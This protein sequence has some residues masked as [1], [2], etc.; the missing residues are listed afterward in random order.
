VGNEDVDEL[1]DKGDVLVRET[2]EDVDDN[3]KVKEV[4]EN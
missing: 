2:S 3:V 1:K 4:L